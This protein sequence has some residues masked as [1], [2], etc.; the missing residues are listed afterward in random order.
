MSQR[1]RK[2]MTDESW[3]AIRHLLGFSVTTS[4]RALVAHT[5][6]GFEGKYSS[7]NPKI[8]SFANLGVEL[9]FT[10]Q[11]IQEYVRASSSGGALSCSNRRA[12]SQFGTG[13]KSLEALL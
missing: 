6:P 12:F 1:K 13:H 11:K 2:K 9:Y 5:K 7:C 3:V 10:F 8:W 4:S